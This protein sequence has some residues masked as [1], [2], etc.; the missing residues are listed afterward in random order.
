MKKRDLVKGMVLIFAFVMVV[1]LILAI[2]PPIWFNSIRH[3]LLLVAVLSIGACI[4]ETFIIMKM[5]LNLVWSNVLILFISVVLGIAFGAGVALLRMYLWSFLVM[6]MLVFT[7]HNAKNKIKW[8]VCMGICLLIFIL[9][10]W[11]RGTVYGYHEISGGDM[12]PVAGLL[13][14]LIRTNFERL[15]PQAFRLDEEEDEITE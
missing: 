2:M 7:V 1:W 10:S 5:N 8:Y 14:F 12:I 15:I 9:Y 3:N 13:Y 11:V 4:L 6:Q